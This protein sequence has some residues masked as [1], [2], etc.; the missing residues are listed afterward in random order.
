MVT[1]SSV[2]VRGRDSF[3]GRRPIMSLLMA[4]GFQAASLLTLIPFLLLRTY[5]LPTNIISVVLGFGFLGGFVLTFALGN[6]ADKGSAEQILKALQWM[7]AIALACIILGPVFDYNG[8]IVAFLCTLCIALV[9]GAG[10][11]K[12]RVRSNIIPA[13]IRGPFN[14]QF[15]RWF[16]V[17][18]EVAVAVTAFALWVSPASS[19]TWLFLFPLI[20]VHVSQLSLRKISGE[21]VSLPA[22]TPHR[23]GRGQVTDSI[24]EGMSKN[25]FL[26]SL[27]VIAICSLGSALPSAG[28]TAWVASQSVFPEFIVSLVS[29]SIL[30]IDFWFMK[31]FGDSLEVGTR[32]WRSI[33][34]LSAVGIF[35]SIVS[36]LAVRWGNITGITGVVLIII[37]LV[38]GVLSYTLSVLASM[39]LQ[40]SYGLENQRGRISALTRAASSLGMAFG[41]AVAPWVFLGTPWV[42][43]L[44][45]FALAAIITTM[46]IRGLRLTPDTSGSQ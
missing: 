8:I 29:V 18:G 1:E 39:T 30:A 23:R 41:S 24:L 3:R 22:S 25:K 14:S 32:T 45:G 10:P 31:R 26:Y 28:L 16:L 20:A 6:A 38:P 33:P 43:V 34:I 11:V 21:N 46:P 17:V 13:S 12:D 40:F 15:R 7:Q 27:G 5:G 37:A 36:I 44:L 19:T 42:V 2:P 35:L 9:R 4:D